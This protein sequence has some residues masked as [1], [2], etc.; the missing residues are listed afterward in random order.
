METVKF[1]DLF[2]G[3]GGFRQ[4][5][6][7]AC[8]ENNLIPDCVFSSDIDPACQFSY[9]ENFGER[10]FGDITKVDEKDIPDHDILFAGFP[11]QP[12]SIIGQRQGFNDIRGTLFFDIA[13]ILKHKRPTAFVLENVKQLVGH[14]NGKTLKII[15]KTLQD[16]DYHVQY[17][18]L[19][20]LDYGLPQKRERVIIVGHRE[21]IFFSFPS[22]IRPFKPLSEI[23]EKQVDKKHYASDYILEKRKAKHKSAYKLSIWHENKAG[24]ICS[25][26]YSCAL[27]AGAS[28]NYLLVNGER[29]LT[30]R[31]MFRLQ[32]FPDTYKIAVSDSQA[33]K[34]AG[35]AVPVNIVKAVILKLLPYVAS[36]MD[37]TSVLRD[38][39]V[40]YGTR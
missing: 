31:E 12:F 32:G 27:R 8:N 26:P 30:P 34:Q 23:L 13:R 22:P 16:L 19:N 28:Y 39:E 14:D 7:E 35:N 38:Y 15:I 25:Y 3:I 24:N 33:R 17:A 20:A 37:I 4:A 21:P 2:C 29:R 9:E 6:D 40:E 18:V 1:I 10:P 11:C 36:S 5:M